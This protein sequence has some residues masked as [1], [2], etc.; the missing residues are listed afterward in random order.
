MIYGK[1]NKRQKEVDEKSNAA[2]KQKEFDM[3]RCAYLSDDMETNFI[4]YRQRHIALHI[5][6]DGAKY[7]GFA[8]QSGEYE[9][10][11]EKHLFHALTKVKLIDN[12]QVW[13]L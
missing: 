4:R 8:S 9:E 11:V 2:S 13:C 3:S 5:Q 1:L 6:Y 12:R 10:T 7:F